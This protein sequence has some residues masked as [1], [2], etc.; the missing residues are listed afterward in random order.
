MQNTSL[1][2]NRLFLGIFAVLAF[3]AALEKEWTTLFFLGLGIVLSLVPYILYR[4]YSIYTPRILRAGIVVFIFAAIVLGELRSFYDSFWWWDS[5]LHAVAGFGVAVIAFIILSLVYNN[6]D[7]RS[8]PF[9]TSLFAI[10]FSI[11]LSAVWEIYEF[12]VDSIT[13]TTNMQPSASDT[14]WDLIVATLGASVAAVGGWDH[15]TRQG[16]TKGFIKRIIDE[17]VEKNQ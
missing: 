4:R 5:I 6:S 1:F 10:C 3:L 7:L 17:G 9:L 8:T 15:I 16:T 13:A 2:I 11:A 12:T 14:M